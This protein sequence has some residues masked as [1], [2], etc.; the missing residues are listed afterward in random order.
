MQFYDTTNEDSKDVVVQSIILNQ[1]SAFYEEGANDFEYVITARFL[2]WFKVV[3]GRSYKARLSWVDLNNP[4]NTQSVEYSW[5]MALTA[6]QQQTE[7]QT[8][9][10][11]INQG[12]NNLNENINE[13]N[14]TQQE[15]NDFLKDDSYD[16]NN[17]T[18]NMPSSSEYQS[19]TDSGIDNIFTSFMNAFTSTQT[20]TV[21]FEFP[22]SNGQYVDIR[23]DLVTSKIP[24]PILILIQSF[25][26]FVIARYIVKDVAHTAEKA[27]SGEILDDTSDGNIKTDLL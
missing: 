17:I 10:Q 5:T 15:T 6:E 7:E 23:S 4:L 24:Q 20:Q 1:N 2:D 3:N 26:W 14:N 25:Y 18:D 16:K 22:N 12:I 19:P 8:T 27:K 13:L 9:Q 11:E 21:R